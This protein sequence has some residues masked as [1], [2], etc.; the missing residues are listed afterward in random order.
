MLSL[1]FMVIGVVYGN[2]DS[3]PLQDAP[4]SPVYRQFKATDFIGEFILFLL[5]TIY[6]LTHWNGDRKNKEY[7]RKWMRATLSIWEDNF[8][9]VGDGQGHKLI[10]DGTRDY[11]FYA[12]GRKYVENVYASLELVARNDLLSYFVHQQQGIRLHDR[13]KFEITCNANDFDSFVF[14]ILPKKSVSEILKDRWDLNHFAKPCSLPGF[15][16]KDFYSLYA[17]VPEILDSLLSN[18][19]ILGAL[20]RFL[21]LTLDS[22]D[23][24]DALP[25]SLLEEWTVSDLPR[26]KPEKMEDLKNVKKIMT[27]VF[28]LPSLV[29]SIE[30][31]KPKLDEMSYFI[32]DV[33]DFMGE[34]GR[35][36][37]EVSSSFYSRHTKFTYEKGKNKV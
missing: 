28:R 15:S 16:L 20:Y 13:V 37:N 29:A 35:L 10:R 25:S 27:I 22:K 31:L 24:E 32:M 12:S 3:D 34:C 18:R 11:I 5:L 36:S 4:P 1:L 7:A 14:A 6:I 9:L 8:T 19:K 26:T 21:G 2:S 30:E 17:D 23:F 33:L